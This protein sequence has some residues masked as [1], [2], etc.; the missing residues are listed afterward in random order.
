V[1][2]KDAL[3]GTRKGRPSTACVL[4]HL[5]ATMPESEAADVQAALDDT[6]VQGS[7]IARA[8]RL[9]GHKISDWTVTRH[10]R[11]DCVGP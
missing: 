6:G 8:L 1:A 4:C 11:G 7:Q 3:A 9:E 2:F 5:L 10:R